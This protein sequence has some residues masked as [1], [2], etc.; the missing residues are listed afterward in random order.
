MLE[1][2]GDRVSTDPGQAVTRSGNGLIAVFPGGAFVFCGTLFGPVGVTVEPLGTAP[3]VD[4]DG[5]DAVVEVSLTTTKVGRVEV[6]PWA[7]DDPAPDLP[8]LTPQGPGTYRM[9]VHA[10]GREQGWEQQE[11]EGVPIEHHLIQ[12]WPAPDAPETIYRRD[13]VTGL[14]L[15]TPT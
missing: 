1:P 14:D 10:R 5:W 13:K 12:V 15:H 8:V 4:L 6:A 2:D 7:W 11:V 9:R 3:R